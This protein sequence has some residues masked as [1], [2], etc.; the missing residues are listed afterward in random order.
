MITMSALDLL[1]CAQVYAERSA[2][3]G[4]FNIVRH[5]G[6]AAENHLHIATAHE[7]HNIAAC[8]RMDDGWSQ[9]EKNFSTVSASLLHL[10]CYF[11]NCQY[12]HFFR[13]DVALHKG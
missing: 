12:F 7:F 10:L 3:Q 2:E 6:I 4:R 9:H 8:A 13:G 5:D 1:T 11:V